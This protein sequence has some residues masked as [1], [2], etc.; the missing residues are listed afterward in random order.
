MR[1]VDSFDEAA[2]KKILNEA[3][4][5]EGVCRKCHV[6]LSGTLQELKGHVCDGK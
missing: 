1:I 5:W 6:K 3:K 4:D 2:V